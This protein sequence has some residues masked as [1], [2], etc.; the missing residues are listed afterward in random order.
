MTIDEQVA[1]LRKGSTEIIR[2]D[3]LRAKLERAAQSGRPLRVKL[4]ADP[5]RFRS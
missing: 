5:V 2:E 3:E 1:Y 4:G